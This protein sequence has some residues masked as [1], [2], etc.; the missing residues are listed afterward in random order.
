MSILLCL[1]KK[2]VNYNIIILSTKKTSFFSIFPI[3]VT[4]SPSTMTT[5]LINNVVPINYKSTNID[6]IE[7]FTNELIE[8]KSQKWNS[9]D[10][11]SKLNATVNNNSLPY[12][13]NKLQITTSEPPPPSTTFDFNKQ[14]AHNFFKV[15]IN[16]QKFDELYFD[17]KNFRQEQIDNLLTNSI[18]DKKFNSA[19]TIL[20][21]C[22]KYKK[23]PSEKCIFELLEYL[24]EQ[25]NLNENLL[26]IRFMEMLRQVNLTFYETHLNFEYFIA[27]ILW[28]KGNSDVSLSIL[29]SIYINPM[30]NDYT[31]CMMTK[32]FQRIVQETLQNRSEAV[33]ITLTKLAEHFKT[34][35]NDSTVLISIWKN[36]FLSQWFSDQQLAN[37]LFNKYNNIRII[38]ANR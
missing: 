7:A 10:K 36:C 37:N 35:L 34:E 8:Q 25:N 17:L 20:N 9:L 23:C 38:I 13:I 30:Q 12:D 16:L 33:L 4:Q 27:R 28:L 19:D 6:S 5:L 1:T 14:I 24:C 2:I 11:S 22:I 32:I 21:Q 29:K 15:L 26:I 31:K 18:Y 3:V